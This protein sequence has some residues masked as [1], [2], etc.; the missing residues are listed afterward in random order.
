[1][2]SN[3]IYKRNPQMAQYTQTFGHTH[4]YTTLAHTQP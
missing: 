4:A 1:M 2:A 3:E